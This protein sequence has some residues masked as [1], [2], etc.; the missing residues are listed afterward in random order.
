MIREDHRGMPILPFPFLSP[1]LSSAVAVV[2]LEATMVARVLVERA[3]PTNPV[4]HPASSER[5]WLAS[6]EI[7]ER[8]APEAWKE[9]DVLGKRRSL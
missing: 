7:A 2:V 9:E 5:P 6:V 3:E 4:G 8:S 1:F